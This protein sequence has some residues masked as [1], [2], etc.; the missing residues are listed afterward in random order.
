MVVSPAISFCMNSRHRRR[1]VEFASTSSNG[2]TGLAL[3][4]IK[5]NHEEA[6]EKVSSYGALENTIYSAC[7]GNRGNMNSIRLS[8][9]DLVRV[10]FPEHGRYHAHQHSYFLLGRKG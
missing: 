9:P 8:N 2:L 6:A 4:R 10:H 1:P 5:G 7:T 3:S